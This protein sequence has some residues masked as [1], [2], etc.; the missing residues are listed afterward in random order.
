M[1]DLNRVEVALSALSVGASYEWS[2]NYILAHGLSGQ[3]NPLGHA[4]DHLLS[5]PNASSLWMAEYLLAKRLVEQKVCKSR[6]SI[7]MAREAISFWFNKHC[8]AC[9]GTG[10]INIEQEQCQLCHGTGEKYHHAA[11]DGALRV[12]EN[13]VDWMDNQLRKR[14]SGRIA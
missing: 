8:P 13:A 6:D 7:D 5:K 10:V 4:L 11:I 9:R 1:K 14:I 2:E 3:K 12:I